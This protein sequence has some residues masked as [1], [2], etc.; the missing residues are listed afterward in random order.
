MPIHAKHLKNTEQA[1]I[2]KLR[3][4]SGAPAQQSRVEE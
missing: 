1:G 4:R 3:S 2:L